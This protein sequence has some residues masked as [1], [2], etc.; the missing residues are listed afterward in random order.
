MIKIY[1]KKTFNEISE[2]ETKINSLKLNLHKTD[3]ITSKFTEAIV[4]YIVFDDKS[5]VLEL[6]A[7]YQ[8]EI[9]NRENLRAE[10]NELETELE[11]LKTE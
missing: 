2:I 9:Q 10:I 5:K 1:D 4:K 3:Y 11:A 8:S 7:E 6:Y